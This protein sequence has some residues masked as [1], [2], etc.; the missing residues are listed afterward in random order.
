MTIKHRLSNYTRKIEKD[1]LFSKRRIIRK[2][3]SFI[4]MLIPIIVLSLVVLLFGELI[5]ETL[6]DLKV[7]SGLEVH[8]DLFFKIGVLLI[9]IMGIVFLM[10]RMDQAD[11]QIEIMT[12]VNKFSNY[13]THREKFINYL[14]DTPLIQII[15]KPI[16]LTTK[17]LITNY[18]KIYF[19]KSPQNF[20]GEP[21][22]E[23]IRRVKDFV[24][25]IERSSLS[26][27]YSK[28]ELLD[29]IYPK[30]LRQIANIF[31]YHNYE[32]N[33]YYSNKLAE[34]IELNNIYSELS[35]DKKDRINYLANIYLTQK[36]ILEI[37]SF[38]EESLEDYNPYNFLY[39]VESYFKL[40]KLEQIIVV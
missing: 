13:Y 20:T 16:P 1:K 35:L 19:G 39:N 17:Q 32:S 8:H 2:F 4:T 9:G 30:T 34:S 11:K 24:S 37:L 15:S 5:I 27:N 31:N 29:E 10:R 38:S 22:A 25:E 28:I 3:Q 33:I 6:A 14:I 21:K 18:H 23:I 26:N 40:R 12:S 7:V 36:L